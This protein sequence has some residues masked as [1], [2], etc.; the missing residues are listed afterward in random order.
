M[1][2]RNCR[3]ALADRDASSKHLFVTARSH[4]AR[5]SCLLAMRDIGCQQRSVQTNSIIRRILVAFLTE[6]AKCKVDNYSP[7]E[8]LRKKVPRYNFVN[9]LLPHVSSR[10][11]RTSPDASQSGLV[12]MVGLCKKRGGNISLSPLWSSSRAYV[13][14]ANSHIAAMSLHFTLQTLQAPS[15]L[16]GVQIPAKIGKLYLMTGRPLS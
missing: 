1:I 6:R 4:H 2:F 9:L 8:G 16:C 5:L 14:F 7:L 15:W 11:D 3:R 12:L 10:A 13:A